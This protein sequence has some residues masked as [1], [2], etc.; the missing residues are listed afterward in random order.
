MT[1]A[2]SQRTS[3]RQGESL[4]FVLG[5][6]PADGT[7]RIEDAVDGALIG[8]DAYGGGS[9]HLTIEAAWR[10]GL[11][12]AVF[13]P[14]PEQSDP[15][16]AQDN[17]VYFVVRPGPPSAARAL[18][19]VP[20]ATWQAYNRAGLPGAGLYWTEDPR[21]ATRVS[22]DRPGGGPPPER[23]EHGML[24]WLGRQQ[25]PVDYCSN[26]DLHAEPGLL[27]D[28]RLLLI[29]GHD[30]YWTW[31][32][33]DA[34]ETFTRQGGNVAIFGANTCWWQMRLEDD[35]RTMICYRD[36]L[37]DPAGAEGKP[38]R[39]TVE[40][41]SA[42]VCRPENA[43]TGL[44]YRLG[45]G[46]WTP[47]MD[48]MRDEEYTVRFADHW[49][50]ERTGL[51][52]GDR[53]GQG[54]LGYETDAADLD[55]RTGAPRVTGRD[56]TPGTF[57]VLATADLRHWADYGQGGAATMGVFTSG[58]GTVFNAGTVNW[59]AALAD[60]VVAQITTNVVSRLSRSPQRRPEWL[61]VGTRERTH[62][63]TAAGSMLYAVVG[64][65]PDLFLACREA[66]AQNLP[67]HPISGANC[68][69]I[70]ALAS[71]RDAVAGAPGGIYALHADGTV[72]RRPAT[73]DAAHWSVAGKCPPAARALA[74][75]SDQLFVLDDHGTIWRCAREQL[76]DACWDKTDAVSGLRTLTAMNGRLYAVDGAGLLLTRS[77]TP[78]DG[79]Q[80]V[81]DGGG[82][83]VLAGHA[84]FLYGTSP[85]RP[86][87][88]IVPPVK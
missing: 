84:G 16:S 65:P 28:Y 27:D 38:E 33:R 46:C 2:Y 62:A 49:A 82:C 87:Q 29:V 31:E 8:Q 45:A 19:S 63:L 68:A 23:W 34:V 17:E 58:R 9:W 77:T 11:Y 83:T 41:S 21:R 26:L 39:T 15:V 47:S 79:W 74:A 42:P 67:W 1:W 88:R 61:I 25:L 71:P 30:E 72:L 57:T 44:S 54:C 32:M 53:F 7:V 64:D 14:G 13:E 35:G 10:S 81:G 5:G 69:D 4:P 40:W 48:P 12:R 60:P 80:P 70:V 66:C 18:L 73:Q 75:A 52:D 37:A 20:F 86:L 6:T 36:A 55:E 85:A 59:G 50:F 56:G 51:A 24:A 3:V 43:M 78:A 76:A 22:F